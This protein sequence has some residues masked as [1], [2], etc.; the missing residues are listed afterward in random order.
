MTFVSFCSF[1]PCSHSTR[2]RETIQA[3]ATTAFLETYG[4]LYAA[5][6]D[7]ANGYGPQPILARTPEQVAALMR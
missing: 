6:G 1:S 7:A 2:I 5:T 3:K 4:Q